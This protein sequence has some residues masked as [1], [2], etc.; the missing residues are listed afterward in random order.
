MRYAFGVCRL[1]TDSREFTRNGQPVHLT[2]K[3][4]DLL[5]LLL[6]ARPRVIG[7]NELMERLWPDAFVV[8]ANLPVLVGDL[9]TAIGDH[10]GLASA[11]KTHH[12]VG[13]SFA[14]EVRELTIG[15]AAAADG[16]PRFV[17]RIGSRRVALGPGANIIG[18]G[19][20]ADVFVND[21]S[22]SRHHARITIDGVTVHVEDLDSKNGT[23]IADARIDR[24]TLLPHGA[25]V[26][27]GSV[28]AMLVVE[29]SEDPTTQTL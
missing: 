1:D 2:P 18:R 4:Y 6:D 9:R 19:T 10:G 23:W 3:A 13:Y 24:S 17:L 21:A 27:F 11:I 20:D 5:K 22:V 25:I 15:A 7:K 8:E 26:V 29:R 14:A 28:E 16:G 12:G